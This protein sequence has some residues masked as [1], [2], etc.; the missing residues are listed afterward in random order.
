MA[1]SWEKTFCPRKIIFQM[2]KV[3][4]TFADVNEE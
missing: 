3:F 2:A 1:D 4:S